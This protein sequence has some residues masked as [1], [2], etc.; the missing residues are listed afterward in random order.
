[1]VGLP[2]ERSCE[3]DTV[4]ALKVNVPIDLPPGLDARPVPDEAGLAAPCRYDQRSGYG[5]DAIA[6]ALPPVN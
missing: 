3:K 2:K 6:Q 5:V 1:M 4:V